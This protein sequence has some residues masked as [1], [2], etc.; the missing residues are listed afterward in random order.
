VLAAGGCHGW[1]E[2]PQDSLGSSGCYGTIACPLGE[3]GTNDAVE[4]GLPFGAF[5]RPIVPVEKARRQGSH[6]RRRGPPWLVI[7]A[8]EPT[9]RQALGPR[10][11]G[12]WMI[13]R[14]GRRWWRRG[15]TSVEPVAARTSAGAVYRLPLTR[16]AVTVAVKPRS[17]SGLP[18]V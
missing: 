15:A 10:A 6:S 7:P 12:P 2:C 16:D 4:Q 11:P 17:V 14:S 13:R 3:V 1:P 18:A 5:A 8:N 9:R